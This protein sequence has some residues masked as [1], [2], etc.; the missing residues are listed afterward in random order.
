[1]RLY[2]DF[3][4]RRTAQIVADAIA[5]LVLAAAVAVAVVVHGAIWALGA[6]G[7]QLESAGT[8]FADTMGDIGDRLGGIPLLGD[9][10]R[11]PFDAASGA[12]GSLA[13]AGRATQ[14]IIE[15]SATLVAIAIVAVPLVILVFAWLLPR[16]RFARRAAQVRELAALEDGEALLA[17]RA[18]DDATS[19]ELAAISPHPLRDWRDGDSR[20]VHALAALEARTAGVRLPERR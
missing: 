9:G 8:G 2:A 10:I 20:A 5:V 1:M 4:A 7:S 17:L 6:I 15:T 16:L 3:A 12:G 11:G 13:D 14:G 18:L 19:K